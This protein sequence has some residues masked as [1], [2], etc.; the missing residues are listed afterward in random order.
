LRRT[1]RTCY[2]FC[3]RTEGLGDESCDE[4]QICLEL[5]D[6]LGACFPGCT[7]F[8]EDTGCDEA[9]R[10]S[11]IPIDAVDRGLCFESGDVAD[12]ARCDLVDGSVLGSCAPG[13]VCAPDFENDLNPQGEATKGNCT[14]MCRTFASVNEYESGCEAN[15]VCSIFG[16][17]WGACEPLASEPLNTGDACPTAGEWCSDDNICIQVDQQGNNLC[18][19]LCRLGSNDDCPSG[20]SCEGGLLQSEALGVCLPN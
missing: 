5:N 8:A 1:P 6:V 14:S 16:T 10:G 13:L 15:E 7:P 20:N 12:G 2:G 4:G 18:I 17:E 3:N 11:C 19:A 9:G